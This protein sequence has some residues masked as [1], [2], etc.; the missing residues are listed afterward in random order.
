MGARRT[1]RR[2][3]VGSCTRGAGALETAAGARARCNAAASPVAGAPKL[4]KVAARHMTA[5]RALHDETMFASPR[6]CP[7]ACDTVHRFKNEV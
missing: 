3:R 5:L 7:D 4:K 2:V 1:G 6:V